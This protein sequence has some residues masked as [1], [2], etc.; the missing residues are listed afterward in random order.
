M[1]LRYGLR[2]KKKILPEFENEAFGF[3]VLDIA[4]IIYL[5]VCIYIWC[6]RGVLSILKRH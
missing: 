1:V 2:V 4:T 6:G 3:C 5:K